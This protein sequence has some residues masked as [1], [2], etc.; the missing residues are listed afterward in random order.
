MTGSPPAARV[1]GPVGGPSAPRRCD[2]LVGTDASLGHHDA[3]L[4]LILLACAGGPEVIEVDLADGTYFAVVPEGWDGADPLPAAVHFHGAGGHPSQY[5]DKPDVVEDFAEAGVLL[6]LPEG[7][8]GFFRSDPAL[9]PDDRDDLAFT[10]AV[11]ADAEGRWPLDP[12]RQYATGFSVGGAMVAALGCE[13]AER[14]AALG[15]MS[16]G[17]WFPAPEAC[18]GPPAPVSHTHGTE[19]STWPLEGRCFRYADDTG[20]CERGQAPMEDNLAIWLEQHGCGEQTA[21]YTDGPQTCE[22]W[23]DC[24]DGE[25]Q[26]CLHEEGHTR[27]DGWAGRQLDWLLGHTR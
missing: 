13:R 5:Y 6:L 14:Y 18:G 3:V 11:W 26:L 22:V 7:A 24:R 8:D 10:E 20:E 19:D 21:V 23:T 15:P 2:A 27:L 17:F 16:G 4:T 9:Y 1:D 25:V 12:D